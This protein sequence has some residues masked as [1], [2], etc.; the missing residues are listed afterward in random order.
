MII[1]LFS[2]LIVSTG[3]FQIFPVDGAQL[4]YQLE[5]SGAI[6]PGHLAVSE[7]RSDDVLFPKPHLFPTKVEVN[8]YGIVTTAQSSIVIDRVSGMVL[9]SE[10]P[11]QKRS[12]GSATKMMSARV[13]LDHDPDLSAYAKLDYNLD[14]VEG[15]RIY[16]RFDDALRVEDVLGASLVGSDNTATQSLARLI[17]LSEE[18]FV[19]EMNAMAR[20]LG[21][22]DTVFV[23]PTGID[24]DNISTAK[25]LVRL[26]RAVESDEILQ[27]F[28]QQE[29]ISIVQQSGF[30]VTIENTNKLLGG[31]LDR[32]EYEVLGGKTGFLPEAGYVLATTIAERDHA[33]DIVVLGAASKDARINEVNGLAQWAFKTFDWLGDD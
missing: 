14:L 30:G 22:A 18:E 16:L 12:I 20:S 31:Y 3:L 2:G 10:Q 32:G 1:K 26:L 29:Q 17:G 15:G 11:D 25:D 27:R 21:M 24:S 8:S 13:F 28:M 4:E 23:E 7:V 19:A 9:F 6:A 33:V 5:P